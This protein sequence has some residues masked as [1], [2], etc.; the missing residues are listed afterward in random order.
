VLKLVAAAVVARAAAMSV[1]V[2]AAAAGWS[3]PILWAVQHR[4]AR[5]LLLL[6]GLHARLRENRRLAAQTKNLPQ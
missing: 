1:L 2:E 3:S 4:K 5:L 6:E